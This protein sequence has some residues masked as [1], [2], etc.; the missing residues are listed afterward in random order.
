[1]NMSVCHHCSMPLTDNGIGDQAWQNS[2]VSAEGWTMRVRCALCARDMSSE[3]KGAAVLHLATE[4]PF[5][6]VVVISDEAGNLTTDTPDVVF[7]EEVA[8]HARC[9]QWS[10]AFTNRAAFNA[11]V[12]KHPRF[13][14]A[15]P[16]TFA[17]W[18]TR[19]SSGTPNTYTPE[20]GPVENPYAQDDTRAE[21]NAP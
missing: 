15:K 14:D 6:T 2:T 9:S 4:D 18:S 7:L 19:E 20:H 11:Y 3:T 5:K 10:Q 21:K 16:L 12:G 1:M 13:K 8:N 17:E